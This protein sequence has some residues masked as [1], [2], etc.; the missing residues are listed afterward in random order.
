MPNYFATYGTLRLD[1]AMRNTPQLRNA[2]ALGR[3]VIPGRLYQSGAFPALKY[4]QGQVIGEL[5]QLPWLFDFTTF[6]VYEDY[7]PAKPW[8][9]RYLRRRVRLIEPYVEAWVYYYVWP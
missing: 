1:G 9:C 3:C 4:G 7:L 5:I 6:D 2:R 8:E